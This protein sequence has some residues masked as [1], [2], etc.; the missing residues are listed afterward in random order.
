MD[1]FIIRSTEE[2]VNLFLVFHQMM[3]LM[4]A[5]LEIVQGIV[6]S[7]MRAGGFGNPQST[8]LPFGRLRE[9]GGP[10]RA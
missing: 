9:D 2:K 4:L 3:E 1:V 8:I 5:L 10:D 6:S 7:I